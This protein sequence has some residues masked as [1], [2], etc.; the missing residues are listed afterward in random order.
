MIT[1]VRLLD[2]K[3]I[4]EAKK[5]EIS[6]IYTVGKDKFESYNISEKKAYKLNKEGIDDLRFDGFYVMALI[7]E[8]EEI[9]DLSIAILILQLYLRNYRIEDVYENIDNKIKEL[10]V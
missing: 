3:L 5:D 7:E 10:S 6:K 9:E 8:L 1:S 4:L 2:K